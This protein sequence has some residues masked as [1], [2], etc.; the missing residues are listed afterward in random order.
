[1]T[2]AN[3][4][5]LRWSSNLSRAAKASGAL[6]TA[7]S[8]LLSGCILSTDPAEVQLAG[9]WNEV[10]QIPGFGLT[11]ELNESQST[12]SGVGT[13][14]LE[15]GPSGTLTVAGSRSGGTFTLTMAYDTGY[16]VSIDA[17]IKSPS[18]FEAYTLDVSGHRQGS[19][20]Q[21]TRCS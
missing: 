7:A 3:P 11:V 18:H 13:F 12:I 21:F 14:H 20:F 9:C 16:V 15:A 8:L 17:T 5:S 10:V 1:M 4:P 19:P 2:V 6:L